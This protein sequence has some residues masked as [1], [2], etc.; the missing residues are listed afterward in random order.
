MSFQLL[1]MSG[2]VRVSLTTEEVTVN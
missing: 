2:I 1:A